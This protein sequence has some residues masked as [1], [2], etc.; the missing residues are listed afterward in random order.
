MPRPP[1]FVYLLRHVAGNAKLREV[2]LRWLLRA[3]EIMPFGH[4]LLFDPHSWV[5]K[6]TEY[7]FRIWVARAERS[8]SREI[9]LDR[10]ERAEVGFIAATVQPGDKVV[11]IGANIGFYTALLGT[12]VGPEGHVTACEPLNA[13]ADAL[14]RTI[15]ENNYTD[16]VTLHRVALDDRNGS[17]LLRH[18][19]III[20]AGAAHL[21]PE[22]RLRSDQIDESVPAR[23]LD[24][25]VGEQPCAFIKL[26][27]EGAEARI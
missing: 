12:L 11:D 23:T 7:G 27:A 13:V 22:S 24:D 3:D 4:A 17:V 16:R 6:E 10:Y 8:I 26:D 18:A 1:T 9:M 21:A 20:N 15:S 14:E 2:V 25:I 5:I 19:P